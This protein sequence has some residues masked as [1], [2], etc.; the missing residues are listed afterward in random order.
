M[1]GKTQRLACAKCHLLLDTGDHIIDKVWTEDLKTVG[2]VTISEGGVL[3]SNII[4]ANDVIL[5][6]GEIKGGRI[7]A[8]KSL[9]LGCSRVSGLAYIQARDLTVLEGV[10]ASIDDRLRYR[11]VELFGLLTSQLIVEEQLVVRS[12]GGFSGAAPQR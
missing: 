9:V 7:S 4:I 11:K 10:D 1:A 2:T 6:G 12:T 3:T 5:N 8:V